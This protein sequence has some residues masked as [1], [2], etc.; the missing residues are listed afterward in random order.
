MKNAEQGKFALQ[1]T[2]IHCP[3]PHANR[4]FETKSKTPAVTAGAL[5]KSIKEDWPM[6]IAL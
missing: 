1:E 3:F 2:I 6:E 4:L 5:L